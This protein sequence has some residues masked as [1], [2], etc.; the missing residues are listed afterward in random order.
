LNKFNGKNIEKLK[1]F[2]QEIEILSKLHNKN[3]IKY[4]GTCRTKETLNIFL[5]YCIGI[6]INY[7]GGSIAKMLEIYGKFK[8]NLIKKYTKQILEGLEYL[9]AHNIIHRGTIRIRLDIKGANILVD[10]EG[11]CKLSD[12]GG[13][14]IIVEEIEINKQNSF[15]GTP[16]WMAPET[17]KFLETTRYS[18]IWSLGCTVIEM[19]TGKI[20]I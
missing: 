6:N 19:A 18:D 4:Y 13:S 2:E 8:E 16:H 20:V 1:S 14:K 7:P 10:K 12:F 11:I 3:I 9:H 17:I 5:E 15:K